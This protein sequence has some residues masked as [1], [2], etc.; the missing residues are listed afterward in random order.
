MKLYAEQPVRLIRQIVFDLA[1]LAWMW[2]WW[3]IAHRVNDTADVSTVGA[4]KLETNA[5][6]L[7]GNLSEAGQRLRKVPL[8]GDTLQSPF[9]K[10]AGAAKQISFAGRDMA[11]GIDDLGD[12]L[13]YLTA[14]TPFA[15]AVLVWA[16]LRIPYARK[17][18]QAARLRRSAAG[19]EVL[20]LRA[21]Q[22][23]GAA[24]LLTVSQRPAAAW[25]E[26][27]EPAT[28]GLADLHLKGLGLR[29]TAAKSS[30]TSASTASPAGDDSETVSQS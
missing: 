1:V 23:R 17:A 26:G 21:L 19:R 2:T 13:G 15:L 3:R 30:T 5:D 14:A 18:S 4:K 11:V 7:S 10:S 6:S 25:R 24:D 29:P 22:T 8:V 28:Q 27:D 9:D 20:A 12:L 16:L